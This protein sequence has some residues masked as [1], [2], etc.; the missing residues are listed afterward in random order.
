MFPLLPD[1]KR[2]VD[3]SWKLADTWRQME[4]VVKK[5]KVRSIGVSNFSELMLEEI[6][7]TAEIVPAVD[8]LELHVYNPQNKL[9]KYLKSKGIVPQA[10]SPFGSTGGPLLAD[11]Q[12][13]EIAK[14]HSLSSSDVLLGYLV[15]KGCVVLPKSVTA[16]RIASN[17]TGALIAVQKLNMADI[18]TLDGLAAGGKQKRFITPPW[19]VEL[20]FENWPPFK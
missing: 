17:M 10:Y 14:K 5:G 11:D 18:A 4:G 7:P 20:G 12:V 8:Q 3:R 16:S 9:L 2:D 15:A 6:L 19:P 13:A 1:G